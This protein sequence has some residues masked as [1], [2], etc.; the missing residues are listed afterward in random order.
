MNRVIISLLAL[1][2]IAFA[3][4]AQGP[5][6]Y[7]RPLGTKT[8][9]T[10]GADTDA[11]IPDGYTAFFIN[12][13]GRHGARHA[14]GTN[15]FSRLDQFLHEAETAGMLLPE[16]KRLAKMV[17]IIYEVEKNYPSGTLTEVGEAE[18]Y[19]IGKDMGDRYPDV[20]RQ[21]DNCLQIMSTPEIRTVQSA[22]YFLKGLASPS[23]CVE[24]T[25]DDS[26]RLRF[27]SLSPTYKSF[28]KK[29]AWRL[30]QT[31]LE[32]AD[33]YHTAGL[34]LLH[35]LFD[36]SLTAKLEAG[37]FET[38]PTPNAVMT[39]IY[40]AAVTAPGLRAELIKAGHKPEDADVFSILSVKEATELAFVDGAKD[41]FV[42]GPG[43]DAAGIQVRVAAPLLADFIQS[44]DQWLASGKSGADLRFA[45]AE[46]IAPF[47]ALMGCEGSAISVADPAHYDQVWNCAQVM[48]YSANIQWIFY[49]PRDGKGDYLLK[50][51][52]NEHAIHLPVVTRQFPY[53]SWKDV[54]AYYLQKLHEL[55]A[56]PGRDMFTYLKDLQ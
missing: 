21:P 33:S 10:P 14:T 18:Q 32:T 16:G 44:T 6:A 27:F 29:G 52:Y 56:D 46:T 1:S 55:N 20:V 54:R 42:K 49:R 37:A 51:L 38:F 43:L 13:V 47:A 25:P 19:R 53:Y 8:L 9:Y 34:S 31:K 4:P 40:A 36:S 28:E 12:Y 2:A 3:A 48:G 30:A 26:V 41:Y 11:P 24:H 22:E 45:H 15:E 39:A 35:R 17:H 7:A 50:V 23:T 5:A